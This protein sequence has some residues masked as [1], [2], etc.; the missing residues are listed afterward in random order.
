MSTWS[1]AIAATGEIVEQ[2]LH[3]TTKD[4][5]LDM[6]CRRQAEEH[7]VVQTTSTCCAEEPAS[8]GD[9]EGAVGTG[10]HSPR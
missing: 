4:T 8:G 1:L 10:R 9:D 5:R 6:S 2:G 3:P 7:S